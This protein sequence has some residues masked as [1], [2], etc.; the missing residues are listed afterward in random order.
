MKFK[1]KSK[2][3]N[4]DYMKNLKILIYFWILFFIAIIFGIWILSSLT[5]KAL[6]QEKTKII[7]KE[8]VYNNS[9]YIIDGSKIIWKKDSTGKFCVDENNRLIVDS[10]I[11]FSD[12]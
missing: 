12:K 9:F 6:S 1:K 10:I 3:K 11:Y 4:Y 8:K 2:I 7:K 5:D